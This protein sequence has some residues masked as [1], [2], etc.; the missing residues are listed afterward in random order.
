M[1]IDLMKW[2]ELRRCQLFDISFLKKFPR[3]RN[4]SIDDGRSVK[5]KPRGR[6]DLT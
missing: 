3:H 1:A 4:R 2:A 6:L 5:K